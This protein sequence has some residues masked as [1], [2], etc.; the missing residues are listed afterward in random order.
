M[1]LHLKTIGSIPIYTALPT[2]GP[3]WAGQFIIVNPPAAGQPTRVYVCVQD[4]NGNWI[5]DDVGTTF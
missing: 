4:S 1:P 5:W 2:P 3:E